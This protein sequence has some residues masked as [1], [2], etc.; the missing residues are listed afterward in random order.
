MTELK[1][2]ECSKCGNCC[3]T[4]S[5][6]E[7]EEL[8]YFDDDGLIC[9]NHL[10]LPLYDWE[11]EVFKKNGKGEL[12]VPYKIIFDMRNNMSIVLQY[13]LK[14]NSCPFFVDNS[15]LI[16]SERPSTC[17]MFPCAIKLG[18]VDK[19]GKGGIDIF[20]FT[21]HCLSEVSRKE[22]LEMIGFDKEG[23]LSNA[24]SVQV[25]KNIYSRYG[26]SYIHCLVKD[27]ID[28]TLMKF[29]AALIQQGMIEIPKKEY[30]LESLK[31]RIGDSKVV[32]IFELY[33]QIK[34]EDLSKTY[35]EMFRRVKDV[36]EK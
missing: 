34:K 9:L 30:S 31:K 10:T 21:N 8:P 2:F 25:N 27:V 7:K 26:D 11:A 15:C 28:K 14:N 18:D 22:L 33:K 6:S 5:F 12:V 36:M 35:N 17:R 1:K 23:S 3:K 24:S 32:N 16:Y 13:T 4:F 19:D 20:T 29:I